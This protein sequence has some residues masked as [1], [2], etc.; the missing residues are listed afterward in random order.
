[1]TE[2]I[3]NDIVRRHQGGTSIR[4]IAED[5]DLARQTVRDVIRRWQAER[6]GTEA[7]PALPVPQRRSSLLDAH[8]DTIRQLLQRYP[9][10]TVTRLLEEL[11][12]KGFT[13]RYT[14][15]RE[16]VKQL[17]T[18][19]TP[20][21]VVRFETS[22]G[23]QAQMDY[24]TYDLDFTAE[25]RRR[26]HLFSYILGYSRRQYLRFVQTQDL[27][28]TLREHI[29]AF[30]YLGGAARTCLYD[31]MKVVVLRHG[32]EGPLYNPRLLAFATHYGYTPWACRVRRSQTK[33]KVERHF[34]YVEKN[35]LNGRTF[36]SLEH[37]NEVTT[38]W[39]TDVADVRVHRETKQRPIDRH[40]AERPHLI[41][42]PATPYD[43]AAVE[44]RIVNVEGFIVYQQNSYSVPWR[45]IGQALPVR[46]VESELIVYGSLVEEVARHRLVPRGQTGQRVEAKSHRPAAD[47]HV[48]Q[49]LLRE[50]FAELGPLAGRFLDGLI[51]D[52]RYSNQQAL[53]ILG[54]QSTYAR[55]DLLAALERA[56]RFGAYSLN[57]IERILAA[58]AKP[59]SVLD[60]LADRE[61]RHLPAHLSDNPVSPRTTT[62]YRNL[63]EESTDHGSPQDPTPPDP[64]T[65]EPHGDEPHDNASRPA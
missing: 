35:L 45:H 54:L 8:D 13:G 6:T 28:T 16:R 57:A 12:A 14:I 40:T 22:P 65:D 4:R 27:P 24:S 51:R 25:G 19:P 36:S 44:Y 63:V 21:P 11:R 31:N 10:I 18:K 1:M 55:A 52:Q 38:R 59:R 9:D 3:R 37:L 20:E 17:R 47:P 49:T 60:S 62:E 41:P 42:L 53:K 5:L 29:R 64:T 46:V 58:Q 15:L 2:E 48:Q 56:V 26:V 43:V 50:R 23:A 33:G 30:E 34:D 61:R 39:L 7:S 32:D